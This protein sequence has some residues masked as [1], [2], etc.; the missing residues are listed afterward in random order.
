M[1]TPLDQYRTLV[2]DSAYRPIMVVSWQKAMEYDFMDKV[3]I[4]ETYDRVV[5]TPTMEIPLP[6]VIALKQYL[7]FRPVLVKYCKRHVFHRDNYSCQYCGCQ[8]GLANLTIDHI[9]PSSRGGKTV[10]KNVATACGPCNSRKGDRTPK[11]AKMPLRSIPV[12]PD[13]TNHGFLTPRQPPEQ[14]GYYL[15]TG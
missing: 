8:P 7:R 9:Q 14:W 3:T 15:A 13:P 10:W 11:E 6:A 2:L 1:F 5:R 4:V 12:R